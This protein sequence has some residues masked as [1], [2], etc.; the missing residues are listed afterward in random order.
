MISCTAIQID[1]SSWVDEE[2][3][4]SRTAMVEK[5]LESCAKCV[6]FHQDLQSI[7]EGVKGLEPLDP[8]EKLWTSLRFQLE[9]EGLIRD[10]SRKSF[11]S[12]LLDRH[13]PDLKPAW[14]GA[15]LALLLGFGSLLVYDFKTRSPLVLKPV[16]STSHQEALREKLN[17]A[18]NNYQTAI[19]ALSASSQKT[20]ESLDPL[21]AKVFQDNLAT[22]DYYLNE[23][24]Q[25]VENN[26]KNPLAHRYLLAAYKKKVELM[27]TIVTFDSLL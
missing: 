3:N 17:K 8:P 26:P 14:S 19:E 6:V 2:L 7:R 15:I 10:K 4:A 22:M 12:K 21:L 24:K 25:T 11:W 5:H 9:T 18:E 20:L 27:Q 13:F 16:A 23:C 1:I